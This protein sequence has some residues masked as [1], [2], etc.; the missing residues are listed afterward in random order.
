[1]AAVAEAE[2]SRVWRIP[3]MAAAVTE[4]PRQSQGRRQQTTSRPRLWPL[5]KRLALPPQ[6]FAG[7]ERRE[8]TFTIKP[9]PPVVPAAPTPTS[10]PI[11]H[12]LHGD[13]AGTAS[14]TAA[15]FWHGNEASAKKAPPRPPK[16]MPI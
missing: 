11:V 3:S 9:A 4:P 14:S 10:T 16:A 8:P 13:A 2:V 6:A 7:D 1:M 15:T 5:R 12:D